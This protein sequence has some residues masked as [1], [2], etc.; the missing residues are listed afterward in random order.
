MPR[1]AFG[2]NSIF[3]I[4]CQDCNGYHRQDDAA[5]KKKIKKLLATASVTITTEHMANKKPLKRAPEGNTVTTTFRLPTELLV[6]LKRGAENDR[7]SLNSHVTL[8]LEKAGQ[9]NQ[10]CIR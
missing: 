1:F 8:L 3:G 2:V 6:N 7:R 4:W 5:H 10:K 9:D